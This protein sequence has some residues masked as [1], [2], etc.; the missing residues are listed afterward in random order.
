M[1]YDAET[2]LGLEWAGHIELPDAYEWEPFGDSGGSDR[3]HR[4]HR[5]S[6]VVADDRGV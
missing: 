2:P 1:E 5:G 6:R 4:R 3:E